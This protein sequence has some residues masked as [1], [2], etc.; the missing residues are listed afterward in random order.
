MNLS[1]QRL[2]RYGALGALCLGVVAGAVYFFDR[3]DT[4]SPATTADGANPPVAAR[5]SV[6]AK[7]TANPDEPAVP[8]AAQTDQVARLLGAARRLAQDGNFAGAKAVLDRADSLMPGSADTAAA[9]REI[10]Q[11]STPAGQLAL[12]LDRARSAIAQDDSTAAEKALAEVERL[13]PQAPEI[14]GLRQALQDAQQK[15]A[16]RSSHITELLTDMRQ[17]IARHDFAA[18]NRALN[19]AERIDVRDPS[20]E[21][22]RVELARAQNAEQ[23]RNA[24]Q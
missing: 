14:A 15:T 13:S 2:I 5:P 24:Q 21:P 12:Q 17:A 18:A 16:R 10:A 3:S 8:N 4:A 9:R 19:E 23:K 22:A 1:N 11:M 20:I 6:A 7:P